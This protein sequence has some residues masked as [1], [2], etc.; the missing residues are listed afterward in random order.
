MGNKHNS[1]IGISGVATSGKDSLFLCLK[2]ILIEHNIEVERWALADDLK[3]EISEFSL[4]HYG[5]SPFTH[6]TEEKEIVRHLMIAHG[7]CKRIISRGTYWTNLLNPKIENALSE[8][9]LPCV[10]DIRYSVYENDELNWL[11]NRFNGILIHVEKILEN[12]QT[13]QP[14]IPDEIENNPKLRANADYILRWPHTLDKNIWM[15][16]T[17]V[18]LKPLLDKLINA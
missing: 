18:Q 14:T 11:K 13:L 7:K 15:D 8:G 6:D 4:K 10:T 17:R 3:A 2:N 1:I 16:Y 9:K 5:I 12:G